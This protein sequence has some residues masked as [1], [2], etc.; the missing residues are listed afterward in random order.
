MSESDDEVQIT[1]VVKNQS[2]HDEMPLCDLLREKD[3]TEYEMPPDGLCFFHSFGMYYRLYTGVAIFAVEFK[4]SATNWIERNWDFQDETAMG[5]ST[6]GQWLDDD[7]PDRMNRW[8][9]SRQR[10]D[11]ADEKSYADLPDILALCNIYKVSIVVL[12]E[13][14]PGF[15]TT[16]TY[17]KQESTIPWEPCYLV[18]HDRVHFNVALPNKVE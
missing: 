7:I 10:E 3:L 9:Q 8:K 1:R 14:R 11:P 18:Q 16:K 6:I 17:G 13:K 15:W 5:S 4:H 2:F 12:Y